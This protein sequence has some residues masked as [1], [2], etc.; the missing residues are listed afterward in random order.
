[1]VPDAR[2]A[3]GEVKQLGDPAKHQG[4]IKIAS[5]KKERGLGL[6]RIRLGFRSRAA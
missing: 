6:E 3:S 1:M 2:K 4:S 5:K